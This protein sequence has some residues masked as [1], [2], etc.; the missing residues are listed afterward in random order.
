MAALYKARK[1]CSPEVIY[2]IDEAARLQRAPIIPYLYDYDRGMGARCLS[3]WQSVGQVES[4]FERPG[5]QSLTRGMS[6][7]IRPLP[8]PRRP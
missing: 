6:K 2:L 7:G 5:L 3:V 8:Y 4:L 1:P